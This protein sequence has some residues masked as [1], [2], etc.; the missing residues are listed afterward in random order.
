VTV[1]V[2][3]HDRFGE[4]CFSAAQAV[5]A[6]SRNQAIKKVSAFI[7]EEQGRTVEHTEKQ[8][9]WRFAQESDQ[10]PREAP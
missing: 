5:S 6:N 2:V 9:F 8:G 3:T 10:T 4:T 7:T 1:S